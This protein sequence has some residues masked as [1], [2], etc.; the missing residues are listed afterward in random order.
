LNAKRDEGCRRDTIASKEMRF[1]SHSRMPPVLRISAVLALGAATTGCAPSAGV[2]STTPAEPSATVVVIAPPPSP[3][4]EPRVTIRHRPTRDDAPSQLP[5]ETEVPAPLEATSEEAQIV[6]LKERVANG[7]A[8]IADLRML[9]ALCAHQGDLACR[10][11]AAVKKR[12][13][14]A[15]G[16][17]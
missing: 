10:N 4:P 7:K 5:A 3:P 9:I 1:W 11:Q 14:E 13:L 12:E 6:L 2:T 8:R 17:P 15:A 16:S